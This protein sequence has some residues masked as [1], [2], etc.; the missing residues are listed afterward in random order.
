MPAYRCSTPL[1]RT[2]GPRPS[3]FRKVIPA[4][5]SALLIASTLFGWGDRAPRSKSA[6][7]GLDTFAA[8]ANSV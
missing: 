8:A 3:S 6:T 1:Y 2:P 5:S 4:A 7:V